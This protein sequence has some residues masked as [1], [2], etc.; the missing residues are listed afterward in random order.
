MIEVLFELMRYFGLNHRPSSGVKWP[1]IIRREMAINIIR[2]ET[3]Y[4]I[5]NI[6]Y[7]QLDCGY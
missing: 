1:L 4:I 3:D 2:R 7:N 6:R 5:N